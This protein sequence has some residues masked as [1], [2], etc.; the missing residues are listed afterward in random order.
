MDSPFWIYG[1]G[2]VAQ[3]FYTGRI[4]IQWYLSEKHKT[5]ESP[6]MFWIFSIIGSAL[7]F[8]YGYLRNDF[9]III[10]ELFT[11]YIYM[12]NIREKGL[13]DKVHRAT[14]YLLSLIPVIVVIA[15]LRDVPHFSENFLRSEAVP[16][17]LL[18]FGTAGQIIFK[19]RFIY[20]WIYSVRHNE[21]LLPLPFWVIAVIGS[22]MIIIYGAIRHDWILILGQIGIVPS[23][24]NIMIALKYDIQK[25]GHAEKID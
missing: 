19:S 18:V 16:P 14:P 21:S 4:L 6:D 13:F 3:V 25:K 15:L 24:R 7:M 12:W 10:G 9:A 20:Q 23:I 8:L 11:Y 22:L 2:F 17:A 5:V 1:I